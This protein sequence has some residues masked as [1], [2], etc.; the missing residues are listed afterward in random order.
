MLFL[1]VYSKRT[2]VGTPTFTRLTGFA[3]STFGAALPKSTVPSL[4]MST[5]ACIQ[6]LLGPLLKEM[7]PVTFGPADFRFV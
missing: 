3:A 5:T 6:L 2:D 7:W 4:F 1:T